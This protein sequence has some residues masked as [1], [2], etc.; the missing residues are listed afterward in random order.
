MTK[1]WDSVYIPVSYT[2]LDVYKRQMRDISR[3][4][5]YR[6]QLEVANKRAEDLLIAREKLMLA[7]SQ[8][9][10]VEADRAANPTRTSH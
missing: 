10:D 9:S 3:S 5:R 8:G 4:N 2:H 7:T 6:Q 1:E